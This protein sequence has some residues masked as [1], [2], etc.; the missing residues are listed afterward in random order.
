METV[1]RLNGGFFNLRQ[2]RFSNQ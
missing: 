2:I 1:K